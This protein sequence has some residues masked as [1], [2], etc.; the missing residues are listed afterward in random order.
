MPKS[1]ISI[2]DFT[3]EEI[4][5]ILDVAQEFEQNKC[6]NFL[7]DKVIA[8]LFFE[9]STRT[10]LSFE[11]AA[12]RLGARVIGF[13]DAGNTSVSKGET[14]KDTIKMVSNYVDL[15]IMRHPLDGSARYASEV[16]SV[17]VINAGD[18]ANQH[19]SQT[20]L[21]LYTIRQTQGK[22]TDININMV[23]DLKYGRTVHSLL[24]AMSHFS[25]KFTFTAPDE[26]KMP[27]EYKDF[28]DRKGIPYKEETVMEGNINDCDI[29]YMT[30]VQQERFTDPMEYEKVK[31]TYSLTASML[32]DAKPNM[33]ILHPLPR[34]TEISQDV[35]DTPFAYF[36]KQAE[37]G[38]YIRMAII[39]YLLGYR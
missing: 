8:T 31:N 25:P 10:R 32:K 12:N 11:T 17:P 19:P 1:L 21:D 22:L 14:L 7:S 28:L 2:H 13:S 33:K 34:V 35:D 16:A 4:L 23:G 36:F 24:Q 20:L 15:I 27:D 37:N 6:Q 39:A 30:R 3:K 5:H 26:L 9:P 29:L 38:V 18:G